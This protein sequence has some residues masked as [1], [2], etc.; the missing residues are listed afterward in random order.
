M[1]MGGE[2]GEGSWAEAHA[3]EQERDSD[4]FIVDRAQR[5]LSSNRGKWGASCELP[6]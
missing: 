4:A 2:G 5:K 6:P 1:T 3:S